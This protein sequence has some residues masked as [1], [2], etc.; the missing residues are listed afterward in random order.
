MMADPVYYVPD[1]MLTPDV[2]VIDFDDILDADEQ[3]P[4]FQE[5]A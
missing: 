4:C 5:A 3:A 2:V 1:M